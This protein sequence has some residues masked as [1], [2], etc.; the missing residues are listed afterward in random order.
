MLRLLMLAAA[1]LMAQFEPLLMLAADDLQRAMYA[2]IIIIII[3]DNAHCWCELAL[4]CR[5]T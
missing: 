2:I 5:C 4:S 1:F 3:I